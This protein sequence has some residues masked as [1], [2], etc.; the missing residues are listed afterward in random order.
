MWSWDVIFVPFS[1]KVT[2]TDTTEQ[3]QEKI[4]DK[5][6]STPID[7]L[8]EGLSEEFAIYLN[9][10][11]SLKFDEDPDYNFLRQLFRKLFRTNGYD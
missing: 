10:C 8:C 9:Y 5:K 4:G 6:M 7:V 1:E 3:K 2:C 11:H